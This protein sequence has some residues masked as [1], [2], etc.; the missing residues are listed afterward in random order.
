MSKLPNSRVNPKSNN[1]VLVQ[2]SFS[3]LY[4]NFIL[5]LYIVYELNTWSCNL[6]NNFTLKIVLFGTVK[7]VRNSIKS[8]FT[9]NGQRTTFD[10]EGLWNFGNDF[11]I[12]IVIFGVDN[13][14]S[15]TTNNRKNNFLVL[16]KGPTQGINDSTGVVEKRFSIIFSKANAKFCL[17]FYDSGDENY[18]YVNKR[19][20]YK[21]KAKDNKVGIIFV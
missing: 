17:R 13:S 15:S 5:N 1:S 11:A 10:G 20:I 21:F 19:E 6:A 2:K 7:L 16:G 18:L 3:S 12:N 8:K 9:Y 4:S 14:S